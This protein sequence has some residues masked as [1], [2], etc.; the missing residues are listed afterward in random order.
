MTFFRKS[1]PIR[2][3][4]SSQVNSRGGKNIGKDTLLHGVGWYTAECAICLLALAA[5]YAA[6]LRGFDPE[7]QPFGTWVSAVETAVMVAFDKSYVR[8]EKPSPA[9]LKF[10]GGD[11]RALKPE[12]VETGFVPA[13]PYY[14]QREWR[15]LLTAIGLYWRCF[16]VSWDNLGP[17]FA[18]LFALSMPAV[19]LLF[20]LGM[21]R[22]A[23]I[24]GVAIHLFS[25]LFLM[26]INSPRDY[27]KAPFL[28]FAVFLLGLMVKRRFAPRRFCMLA[29]LYG[30]WAGAGLLF[31]QDMII[32]VPLGIAVVFF[33][34]AGPLRKR[35]R[36]AAALLLVSGFLVC[37]WQQFRI[38]REE[39]A[40]TFHYLAMGTTSYFNDRLGLGK[41]PYD[42]GTGH[43]DE[44]ILSNVVSFAARTGEK[45]PCT[46]LRDYNKA[47]KSYCLQMFA[48]LPA[49]TAIR[50]FAAMFGSFDRIPF[51]DTAM[52][53]GDPMKKPEYVRKVTAIRARYFGRLEGTGRWLVLAA[54]FLLLV[55]DVRWGLF[56]GFILLL[57]GG[58][59][60]V[61]YDVR[62]AFYMETA[63][64]WSLLFVIC[65]LCAG[66]RAAF[67]RR[68][69]L[70][71]AARLLRPA[72]LRAAAVAGATGLLAVLSVALLCACQHF[73]AGHFFKK[74]QTSSRTLVTTEVE[75]TYT[76][77]W[78]DGSILYAAKGLFQGEPDTLPEDRI[79]LRS[80][81]ILVKLRGDGHPM[82]L[83]LV[84]ENKR[85]KKWK[86]YGYFNNSFDF[87][88]YYEV[89]AGDAKTGRPV[90]LFAPVYCIQNDGKKRARFLGVS[91][92]PSEWESFGGIYRIRDPEQ[93]PLTPSVL[94]TSG[95][96]SMPR[97]LRPVPP[98]PPFAEIEEKSLGE[99][100]LSDGGFEDR[101]DAS[102]GQAAHEPQS[103]APQPART[104]DDCAEGSC[105]CKICWP[106]RDKDFVHSPGLFLIE[107]LEP[108]IQYQLIFQAKFE[109]KPNALVSA[110]NL[111]KVDDD[112]ILDGLSENMVAV[113]KPSDEYKTYTGRFTTP[114]SLDG[115][116]TMEISY[117][118]KASGA[119]AV[120]DDCRLVRVRSMRPFWSEP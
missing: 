102:W 6:G 46:L 101:P 62:H 97:F 87:S 78:P 114:G 98:P 20:R 60:S 74:L 119:C 7:L 29:L 47:A 66:L 51:S 12:N 31:R 1:A 117:F 54:V 25:P 36:L 120:V 35:V 112:V 107:N 118:G 90:Y 96:E 68:A 110:W 9:F 64:W 63:L 95:W 42:F 18:L 41:V 99:N 100:L 73:T 19:Y 108:Y 34:A 44:W 53:W 28:L 33:F 49:D 105:A 103:A 61:Q 43:N 24:A 82:R 32:C 104:P 92:T 38:Y 50:A 15:C 67:A 30:L 80:E 14:F 17:L 83:R 85:R 86:H 59:M 22:A 45:A 76:P 71:E 111:R 55:R 48:L 84:Y 57:F 88:R 69:G 3:A 23:A 58:M 21:G 11:R 106:K 2:E 37:S 52:H 39:G 4:D 13:E 5:G 10:R 94:L 113:V 77:L 93:F 65:R 116:V 91:V 70:R 40:C 115:P 81:Y 75:G 56:L 27:I 109:A 16:G 8:S 72:I 79:T 89:P 26:M